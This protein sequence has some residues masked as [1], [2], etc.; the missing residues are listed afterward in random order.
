MKKLK[1][2]ISICLA[3]FL[4]IAVCGGIVLLT[5]HNSYASKTF[6]KVLIS[7]NS[8]ENTLGVGENIKYDS[9]AYK[10]S[11]AK[12]FDI[13]VFKS[14]DGDSEECVKRVIGLPGETVTLKDGKV[15]I[16]N[17]STSLDEPYLKEKSLGIGDGTYIVPENCYFVL[18]DNRNNSKDSRFWEN[19]YVSFEKI[20][21][22]VK[23]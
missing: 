22:K 21:G 5:K 19:K 11:G 17:S 15:Y 6:K 14:P 1:M 18:G 9:A 13:I 10:N 3:F 4:V 8:M 7:N 23:E 20:L 2:V 16:N 12:R